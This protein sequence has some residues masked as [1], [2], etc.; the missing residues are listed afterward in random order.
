MV[1]VVVI[2]L[3]TIEAI[4]IG[5]CHYPVFFLIPVLLQLL[6]LLLYK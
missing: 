2:T 5:F 6:L 3:I 4:V 1:S